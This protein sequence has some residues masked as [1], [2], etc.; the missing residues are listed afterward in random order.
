M[1]EKR[2]VCLADVP[3][4][5]SATVTSVSPC[6]A[7]ERLLAMGFI[8]GETVAVLRRRKTSTV[9]RIRGMRLALGAETAALVTVRRQT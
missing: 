2:L 9:V 6:A 1:I 8:P 7:G 4:G 5:E 3:P